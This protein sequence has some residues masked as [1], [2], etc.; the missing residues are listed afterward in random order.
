MYRKKG[1]RMKKNILCIF[2]LFLL[3]VPLYLL[4]MQEDDKFE[5]S[6]VIPSLPTTRGLGWLR[7]TCDL[8]WDPA[9]NLYGDVE[10][11]IYDP[12]N[13]SYHRKL[14]VAIEIYSDNKNS[15]RL[16]DLFKLCRQ[17]YPQ[18][19]KIGDISAFVAHEFLVSENKNKQTRLKTTI[20]AKDREFIGLQNILL[21]ALQQT[22]SEQINTIETNLVN[23]LACRDVLIKQE[24]VEIRKLK[25]GLVHLHHLNKT[26]ILP[27]NIYCSDDETDAE[28][29]ENSYNNEYLLKKI[30][31]DFSM[32]QTK[33]KVE[34]MLATLKVINDSIQKIEQLRY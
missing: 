20:E 4:C 3:T 10:Q 8:I 9:E 28:N 30:G 15:S 11:K 17:N 14:D 22:I 6:I 23:H 13:S 21:T 34:R 33:E 5:Q 24:G 27:D 2:T 31:V 19:I 29:V 1:V 12:Y 7:S 16:I 25:G 18:K 26:I 32:N